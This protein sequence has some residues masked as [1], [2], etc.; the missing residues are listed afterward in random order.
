MVEYDYMEDIV[1]LMRQIEESGDTTRRTQNEIDFR[2]GKLENEKD[3]AKVKSLK[4][5]IV[6]YNESKKTV[7]EITEKYIRQAKTMIDS[8]KKEAQDYYV[9][10]YM[11]LSQNKTRL[12][13][14]RKKI[15]LETSSERKARIEEKK[16]QIEK[17][18][19][20][21]RV[22]NPEKYEM[23]KKAAENTLKNLETEEKEIA[24]ID[25]K[26][27]ETE[28]LM[29][30]LKIGYHSNLNW[31]DK[32]ND[33]LEI[34]LKSG[35]DK[36]PKM[37][38]ILKK[39]EKTKSEEQTK[40]ENNKKTTSP[41]KEVIVNN[42]GVTFVDING[43]EER[44]QKLSGWKK[45]KEIFRLVFVARDDETDENKTVIPIRLLRKINPNITRYMDSSELKEYINYLKDPINN[46]L[47]FNILDNTSKQKMLNNG[48][49][50]TPEPNRG[51][52][53]HYDVSKNPQ[54]PRPF[55]TDERPL[56]EQFRD[57]FEG[58]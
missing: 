55:Q 40:P 39:S 35:A 43:N 3:K 4:S 41:L 11:E 45:V 9:K 27:K 47:S 5:E 53:K 56:G 13:E 22:N 15:Q 58:K 57:F 16:E 32:C 49:D 24:S 29:D 36:M 33:A 38:E 34:G 21:M 50:K 26:I 6:L 52:R 54:T 51:I 28:K 19:R 31:L 30:E 1:K 20:S 25:S 2:Q 17:K 37:D 18:L 12:L 14:K 44:T 48:N 23:T 7:N 8:K 42:D 46:K 10:N